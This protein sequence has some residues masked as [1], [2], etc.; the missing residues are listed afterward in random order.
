MGCLLR[1][2]RRNRKKL[3]MQTTWIWILTMI[4]MRKKIGDLRSRGKGKKSEDGRKKE[5]LLEKIRRVG[6]DAMMTLWILWILQLTVMYPGVIGLQVFLIKILP[7][8]V[9]I[10]LPVDHFSNKDHI[11]AQERS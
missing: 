8:L 2:R 4:V 11:L 3:I 5:E 1:K 10:A 9:S 7:R 6:K